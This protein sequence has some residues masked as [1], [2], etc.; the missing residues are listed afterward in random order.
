MTCPHCDT[1]LQIR[2]SRAVSPLSRELYVQCPNVECAYTCKML[3][4]AIHTIA[5]SMKPNPTVYLPTSRQRGAATDDRQ[6][7][8]LST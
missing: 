2:T 6:M 8:L 7:D 1:R 3:L 4:S 5:P